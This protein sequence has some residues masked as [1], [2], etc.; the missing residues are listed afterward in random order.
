MDTMVQIRQRALTKTNMK[1]L[2]IIILFAVVISCSESKP[3]SAPI[4]SVSIDS[5]VVDTIH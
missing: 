1:K 5:V 4:D 2:I 3:T